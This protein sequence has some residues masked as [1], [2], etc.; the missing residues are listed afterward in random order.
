MAG[1]ML[2]GCGSSAGKAEEAAGGEAEEVVEEAEETE[3]EAAEETGMA[4]PWS[5]AESAEDAAKGAGIDGMSLD[6]DLGLSLGK[7]FER[8]YRFMDGIAEVTLEFPASQITVR[9]GTNA[10]NGDISGDYNEYKN[11]WT[12]DIN[13]QEVTCSGNREGDASKTIW[14]AGDMCYSITA[15]GLGGDDD[16]GLTAEDLALVVEKLK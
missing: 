11:T 15:E 4:N 10:E 8:T 13:G 7:E 14:T 2:A 16:F 6:E 12:Q 9:K 1:I 5:D 3:G